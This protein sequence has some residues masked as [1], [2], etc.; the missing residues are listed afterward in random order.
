MKRRDFINMGLAGTGG[1]LLGVS[2]VLFEPSKRAP[3]PINP[4]V[5]SPFLEI[6]D[7]GLIYIY[8][9]IPEMG[10]G[11]R[12][13]LPM[14]LA[15]AL[16]AH[17][18]DVRVIQAKAADQ[19][20]SMAAAGSTG[21]SRFY[22][23]LQKVGKLARHMLIEA[24]A[25]KWNV[26]PGN[27][28]TDS[29]RILDQNSGKSISYYEIAAEASLLEIPQETELRSDVK[30]KIIGQTIGRVDALDIVTGKA[31]F[32]LDTKLEGMKYA[33]VERSPV[34][35]GQL[36][37]YSFEEALQV[38]NVIDA[39][40]IKG[41]RPISYAE[42]QNGVAVIAESSFAAIQGRKKLKLEWT[43]NKGQNEDNVFYREQY[44]MLKSKV[45]ET[46]LRS[47]E[48]FDTN[49]ASA[50]MILN[51]EYEVPFFAHYCMEPMNFTAHYKENEIRLI[52]PNQ[53]PQL[54]QD[55]IS[56]IHKVPKEHVVVETTLVGGG[57]GRRL[58]V[59]YALEAVEI[60][61]ASGYPVQVVWTR[62]DDSLHDYFRSI[63]FH[64]LNI[65]LKNNRLYSWFHHLMTKPI[66]DGAIY[67]VQGAADL[68]F[69]IPHIAMGY[70]AMDFNVQIGSWRSVAHSHNTFVV[71]NTINEAA[72]ALGRD[73]Y[74]LLLE[75]CGQEERTEVKLPLRGYRGLVECDLTKLRRVIN[76][77]AE[78]AEWKEKYRP[79]AGIGIACAFYK[80]S[81]AAHVAEIEIQDD[82][83]LVRKMTA[84]LDC[85][86]VIHPAG[87]KAQ[88]EGSISDA[89]TVTLKTGVNIKN[90]KPVQTNFHS[91]GQ[92]RIV[93]MPEIN[94][95]I[96]ESSD[97]PSGAGEPPFP[98]TIPAITNAIHNLTGEQIRSLP[99]KR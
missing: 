15:D 46:E 79:G 5:F 22:D 10:Q 36:K 97:P 95:H 72:G 93:D 89:I 18:N 2:N 85:G 43:A 49:E 94:I 70:S 30:S 28:T 37:N 63:S 12:T 68:P 31:Q 75:L 11:V 88:I 7:K 20:G 29:S 40:V 48:N 51:F 25:K 45:W 1:F 14:I 52:G 61:K 55:L 33:S 41:S 99:V 47:T 16:D 66:G 78:K 71:N 8:A 67:E 27:L 81:Y 35:G 50:D 44:A 42:V 26:E 58:A 21:V 53:R 24:A 64:H 62:E 83:Y 84:V 54:I 57:F 69:K 9:P 56:Q 4:A 74:E 90:G 76:V 38:D 92:A 39:L 23:A 34:R 19:Y 65:G 91:Y 3:K 73:P 17:W 13:S 77:A 80:T 86:L 82:Q 6:S 96:I 60:S 59:D 87:V 98:S 32:G